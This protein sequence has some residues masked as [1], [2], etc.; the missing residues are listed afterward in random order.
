MPLT[1]VLKQKL[2]NYRK[3]RD[4]KPEQFVEKKTKIFFE[5]LKKNNIKGVAIALSGGIDS[6][7]SLALA[8]ETKKQYGLPLKIIPVCIP[9]HSSDWAQERAEEMA[10]SI[11]H[12]LRT[13]DMT[14][15]FDQMVPKI[16]E[17]LGDLEIKSD[18]ETEV[19]S[20]N[21]KNIMTEFAKSQLK[22]YIRTPT[23]YGVAQTMTGQGCPTI[24]LGT[25][26]M[27]EDGYLRYF[28]KAGDGVVDIQLIWDCHKSEVFKLG[29]YLNV[30]E[31][32]L[33]AEPSA[34]LYPGQTDKEELQI[35]YDT[36]EL[37]HFYNSLGFIKMSKFASSM[38]KESNRMF[39]ADYK[40]AETIHFKNEHKSKM[41]LNL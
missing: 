29:K 21:N 7:V 31:S 30:P 12:K 24:V 41:P 16:E 22:S 36:I 26:N 2:A 6:A 25:G 9:V 11:Q 33:S 1:E 8:N 10:T 40:K 4:F 13:I 39:M 17:G 23:I 28:C 32:I 5:Y 14:N 35:D 38:D 15:I 27:D 34:D 20:K 19:E 18:T 3:G 37:I